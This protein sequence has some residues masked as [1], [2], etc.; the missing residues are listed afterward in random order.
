M[1]LGQPGQACKAYAELDAVY[2][3]KIRPELKKLKPTPGP[4]PSAAE[5]SSPAPRGGGTVRRRRM[6]E[7]VL[8]T[9]GKRG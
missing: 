1:K 5:K 3:A 6:V 8:S 4:R 9:L 2:G 7:G